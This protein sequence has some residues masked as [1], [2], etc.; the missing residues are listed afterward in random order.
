[1]KVRLRFVIFNGKL[2]IISSFLHL[3]Q[4]KERFGIELPLKR[5]SL[6]G[7]IVSTVIA[8]IRKEFLDDVAA[9]LC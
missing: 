7:H 9:A 4:T 2:R 8:L 3:T 5:A 6:I 1:M